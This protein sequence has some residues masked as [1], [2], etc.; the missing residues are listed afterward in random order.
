M[1]FELKTVG[2]YRLLYVMAAEVEYG[3]HL[4]QRFKPLITGIGPVE[5]AVSITRVLSDLRAIGMLPDLVVSLGSA[6]SATLEQTGIY[7]ATSISYRDMDA[8]P[9]GFEKGVTPFLMLPAVLDLPLRIPGVPTATMSTGANIISGAV[10][11]DI[12]ADMVEMETYAILRACQTF[13]VQLLGLRGISD[14]REELQHVTDWTQYLH[15]IDEKM[16]A[17]VDQ[18]EEGLLD[19]MITL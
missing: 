11:D 17:V 1:T 15:L 5:A 16:A 4:K 6:G 12:D 19:G 3:E 2:D 18:L 9:L 13:D 8:S 10:Y 14:G 7:Q